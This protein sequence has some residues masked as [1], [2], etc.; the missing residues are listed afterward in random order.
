MKHIV[1]FTSLLLCLL[2]FSQGAFAITLQEAKEQGLVGEQADGY[3][4]Y[5]VGSV[6]PEL[7]ALVD[8]VNQQR[9]QRYE[10]IARQNGLQV[11]QVQALAYQEAVEATRSGHYYQDSSGNWVRK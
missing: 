8:D 4:G 11:G 1:K 3:V 10:Q 7:R 5:V 9:R 2:L 6:D